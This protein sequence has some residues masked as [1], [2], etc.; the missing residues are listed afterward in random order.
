MKVEVLEAL[1]SVMVWHYV[2]PIA[3]IKHDL[4]IDLT[5]S[6]QQDAVG[7]HGSRQVDMVRDVGRTRSVPLHARELSVVV[8]FMDI[9]VVENSIKVGAR[10]SI[11]FCFSVLFPFGFSQQLEQ[12]TSC[13]DLERTVLPL[14]V[15]Y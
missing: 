10:S 9:E 3:I 8:A 15:V 11:E 5:Q 14:S 2:V 6:R 4:I 1:N 12:S 13:T 7:L